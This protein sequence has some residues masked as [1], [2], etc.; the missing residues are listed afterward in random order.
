MTGHLRQSVAAFAVIRREE[1]GGTQWLTQWNAHW[2]CFNLIGG[3]KRPDE[4]FRECVIRELSEELRLC[5][6]E[7]FTVAESLTAHLE[8]QAWSESAQ[9]TTAYIVELF[10]VQ[11][12][13][14]RAL[15]QIDA[16]SSNRWLSLAEI[17]H[18]HAAD[19][20]RVSPTMKRLLEQVDS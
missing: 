3:H 6:G 17:H 18:G 10:Q 12:N 14:P 11:L 5:E 4:T 1:R 2:Q 7:D 20:R 13:G 15:D 9:R 16:N 19:D 8:Y